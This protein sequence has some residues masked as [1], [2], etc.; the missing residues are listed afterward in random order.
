MR[1]RERELMA[2]LAPST[3]S[4]SA[5]ARPIPLEAAVTSAVLPSRPRSIR[6]TVVAHVAMLRIGMGLLRGIGRAA[7][8]LVGAATAAWYLRRQGLLG[9]PP[10]PELPGPPAPPA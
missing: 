9:A 3:A 4:P 6:G 10:Q 1:S 2:T 7:P 5:I 8:L